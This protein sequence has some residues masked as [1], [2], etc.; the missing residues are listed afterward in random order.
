[1][2]ACARCCLMSRVDASALRRDPARF[3]Y[4]ALNFGLLSSTV[5]AIGGSMAVVLLVSAL[6]N[7]S[8][9]HPAWLK[10]VRVE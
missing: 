5:G 6:A 4:R 10:D 2:S 1:M 8:G 3:V 9:L 7:R